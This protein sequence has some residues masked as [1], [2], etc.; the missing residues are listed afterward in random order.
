MKNVLPKT[1]MNVAPNAEAPAV[2]CETQEDV[3][4]VFRSAG[5][6]RRVFGNASVVEVRGQAGTGACLV[7]DIRPPIVDGPDFQRG[8]GEP[9][10]T[11]PVIIMTPNGCIPMSLQATKPAVSA[12]PN[13]SGE[14]VL[15]AVAQAFAYDAD[16][17]AERGQ[18]AGVRARYASLS[19]REKEVMGR[20]VTGRMN[21]QIAFEL[22]LQ[23]ITI[24]IHRGNAMR[25]MGARTLVDFS[26]MA[27]Q[28][29]LD[30]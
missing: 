16:E 7:L 24:K 13:P 11:I 25:K 8:F 23:E 27:E 14:D 1:R 9:G 3:E 6:E 2:G 22:G 18:M 10:E 17:R 29:K 5:Y 30:T 28:L 15:D 12:N 21:K 20:V 4:R 26:R 19:P